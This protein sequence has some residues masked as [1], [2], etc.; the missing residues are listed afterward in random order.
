MRKLWKT[1]SRLLAP[2]DITQNASQDVR[3]ETAELASWALSD[4]ASDRNAQSP[5]RRGALSGQPNGDAHLSDDLSH[6]TSN[7]STRPEAILEVSEPSTPHNETVSPHSQS[8]SALTELI[9]QSPLDEDSP[10]DTDDEGIL[11]ISGVQPVIVRDGIISQ[12]SERTSLLLKKV[13][14]G[15]EG[16]PAD[17][18]VQDLEDQKTLCESWL[19]RV[20]G[21]Y[22]QSKRQ[23][24][25]A[26]RKVENPK[27]WGKKQMFQQAVKRPASYI[28]PVILG[29]LLNVLD[30]LSYG[31][32]IFMSSLEHQFTENA[33]DDLV[34]S[35]RT[36]VRTTGT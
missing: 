30:A 31:T 21:V 2:I 10:N 12:P 23:A 18:S 7:D 6:R 34:P 1:C 27:S 36:Y 29:L 3:E 19:K 16:R 32:Q 4:I 5:S 22:A 24:I 13:T 14:Y 8:P 26:A 33:R 15:S 17:G 25:S 20:K 11:S 9:R 35:G 28:A